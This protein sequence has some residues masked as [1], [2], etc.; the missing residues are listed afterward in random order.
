MPRRKRPDSRIK[1]QR[2]VQKAVYF[3]PE[4]AEFV[5][6]LADKNGISFSAQI[7]QICEEWRDSYKGVINRDG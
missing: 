7:M 5:S 6:K 4:M 2:T 3:E 1:G